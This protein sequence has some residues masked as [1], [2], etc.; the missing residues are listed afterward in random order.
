MTLTDVLTFCATANQVER[1]AIINALT[2]GGSRQASRA[3]TAATTL[4]QIGEGETVKFTYDN[5]DYEAKVVKINRTTAT[6][7]I[8]KIIGMPRRSL[9]V[10]STVR[11]SASILARTMAAGN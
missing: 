7:T 3:A 9:F 1:T 6:V 10:G 4:S 2:A 11:V 8:T 5:V